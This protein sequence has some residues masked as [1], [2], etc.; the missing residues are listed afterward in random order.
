MFQI[1]IPSANR[2]SSRYFR[3]TDL[4]RGYG[5]DMSR[6]Y[7]FLDPSQVDLYNE[8]YQLGDLNIVICQNQSIV[9]VRNYIE[10]DYFRKGQHILCLDDDIHYLNYKDDNGDIH[11]VTDSV[12]FEKLIN[13]AFQ[14]LHTHNCLLWGVYPIARNSP[15]FAEA[16]TN[17]GN[18]HIIAACS[19]IIVSPQLPRQNP[20]LTCKEEY[21]RGFI[22]GKNIRVGFLA[23]DTKYYTNDGIGPRSEASQLETCQRIME[24]Y[25]GRY[26]KTPLK[27]NKKKGN[28]DLRLKKNYY[29]QNT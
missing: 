3:T 13:Q 10:R 22:Y 26:S 1:A 21:E 5:F 29:N 15:W 9:D 24:L 11:R 23:L 14:L 12:I 28:V 2:I 27:R 20:E 16:K 4:L 6:V 17:I 8:V 7:L 25:P 18:N 19:G